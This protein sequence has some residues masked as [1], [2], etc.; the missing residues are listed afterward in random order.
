ME[1]FWEVSLNDLSCIKILFG[2]MLLG[3]VIHNLR[4]TKKIGSFG[5]VNEIRLMKAENRFCG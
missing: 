1:D 3:S 5:R 4:D 2:N